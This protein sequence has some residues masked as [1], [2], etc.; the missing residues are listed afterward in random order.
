[1]SPPLEQ[2]FFFLTFLLIVVVY[3]QM[4]KIKIFNGRW[5][6]TGHAYVGAH[7]Q[8]HAVELLNGI[9]G[10][11]FMT[12]HELQIY[13]SKGCWGNAM[14]GIEV[15]VGVWVQDKWNDPVKRLV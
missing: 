7:T 15:Q 11:G 14:A 5:G 1:M 4:K 2:L 12:I 6:T 9:P 13:W 3:L 8:K 10:H